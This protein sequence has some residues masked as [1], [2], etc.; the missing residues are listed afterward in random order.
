MRRVDPG[1]LLSLDEYRAARDR[2]RDDI[3]RYK[4]DRR[5]PMGDLVSVVF[6]NHRT[7]WFQ[8]QEMLRAEHISDPRAV[9]EELAVYNDMLPP[10]LALAATLL[11]EIPDQSQIPTVLRRL[12]GLEEQVVLTLDGVEVRAEAEPGRSR[13]DKTSSVH[14]LTFPLTPSQADLLRRSDTVVRLE[15]RH[16]G[17]EVSE[18][19]TRATRA[20][21]AADLE[22]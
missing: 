11:I 19:L 15:I 13:E 12:T 18:T 6:E 7:M 5:V 3:I 1:D 14:Y 17:Y 9:A 10:G 16:P 20:S 4:K 22:P 2:I 8:T 21:L